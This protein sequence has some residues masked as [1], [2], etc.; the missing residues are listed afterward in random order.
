LAPKSIKQKIK[1]KTSKLL[2]ESLFLWVSSIS[3]SKYPTPA[4]IPWKY[5]PRMRIVGSNISIEL[6]NSLKSLE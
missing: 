5:Q 6:E 2:H 4:S 3:I 1:I